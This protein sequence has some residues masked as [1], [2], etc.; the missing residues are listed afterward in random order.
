MTWTREGKGEQLTKTRQVSIGISG[1]REV[2]RKEQLKG[3]EGKVRAKCKKKKRA[4]KKN[5]I[6]H[7]RNN[8]RNVEKT[9]KG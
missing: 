4:E 1:P 2:E 5:R 7:K 3:N 9:K 6:K 8:R